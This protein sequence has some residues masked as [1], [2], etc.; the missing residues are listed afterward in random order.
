MHRQ[1]DAQASLADAA[2]VAK[3]QADQRRRQLEIKRAQMSHGADGSRQ[4]FVG[5]P[6]KE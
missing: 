3:Y 5:I 6:V 1:R 2:E 4:I